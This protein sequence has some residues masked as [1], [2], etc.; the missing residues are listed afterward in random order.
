MRKITVEMSNKSIDLTRWSGVTFMKNSHKM[1]VFLING[2]TIPMSSRPMGPIP[3]QSSLPKPIKTS[4]PPQKQKLKP[5]NKKN[6]SKKL[7]D[8]VNQQNES[9]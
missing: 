3:K 9:K 5:I 4:L 7:N 2:A 1:D 6:L 8:K